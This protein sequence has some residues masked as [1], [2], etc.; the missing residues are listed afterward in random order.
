M[1]TLTFFYK[2]K[3]I[4]YAFHNQPHSVITWLPFHNFYIVTL[5]IILFFENFMWK[6]L[7]EVLLSL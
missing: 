2:K 1:L 5:D 3:H 4:M 6:F 7:W